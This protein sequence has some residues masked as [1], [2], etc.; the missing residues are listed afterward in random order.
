[1]VEKIYANQSAC[2]IKNGNW[3]RALEAAEKVGIFHVRGV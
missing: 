1:M 3:K 2:H